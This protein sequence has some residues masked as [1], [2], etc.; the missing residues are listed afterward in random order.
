MSAQVL[1][2]LKLVLI[3]V[4]VAG[5]NPFPSMNIE[6]PAIFNWALENKVGKNS[7]MSESYIYH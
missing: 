5:Y 2:I 1:S 4:I 7:W 6:T 3:G